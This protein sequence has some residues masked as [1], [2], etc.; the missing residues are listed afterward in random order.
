MITTTQ[1]KHFQNKMEDKTAKGR[2]S[3]T[4]ISISLNNKKNWHNSQIDSPQ[5]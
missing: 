2:F 1:Q 4:K 5:K 3:T